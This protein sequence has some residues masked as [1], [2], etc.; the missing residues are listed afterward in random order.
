MRE[1]AW[2]ENGLVAAVVQHAETAEVLMLGWMNPAALKRTTVNG[3]V[4]F[5]SRS[6]QELW[7]KGETSGNWLELVSAALDC[8]G[9]SLLIR[10]LPHGPTCH[11]GTRTCWGDGS[12]AGFADLDRLWEVIHQRARDRPGGSYTSALVAA[13]PEAS[14]RKLI[15]EATE[16]LLA[17][18]D[19][20][21]GLADDR[22]V[23]EEAGDV[24]YHL[25]VLL[26]ERSVAPS[27]VLDV[28]A[29]RRR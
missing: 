7:E 2:D 15:E 9:D 29:S 24:I 17:A 11:T 23:A 6:R 5:W 1:P 20:A 25:L 28:L 13:G 4:T 14:G 10:A 8:D 27:E 19:H 21:S 18:K 12:V 22:R 3:R 16:T 26:A